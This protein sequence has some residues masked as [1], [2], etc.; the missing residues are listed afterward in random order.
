IF[1]DL[2]KIDKSET[3]HNIT[4]KSE[5]E[6]LTDVAGDLHHYLG[7]II[8]AIA[9]S[10]S[11]A[12]RRRDH[13]RHAL[14][15]VVVT[16]TVF[17]PSPIQRYQ[18][19]IGLSHIVKEIGILEVFGWLC[20][21]LACILPLGLKCNCMLQGLSSVSDGLARTNAQEGDNLNSNAIF[22]APDTWFF[23]LMS[24]Q[25]S[26]ILVSW[27]VTKKLLRD[28]VPFE[29]YLVQAEDLSKQKFNWRSTKFT[30][31]NILTINGWIPKEL[32]SVPA[33]V[34][35]FSQCKDN[36]A[37]S[38]QEDNFVEAVSNI[39]IARS[40]LISITFVYLR[41]NLLSSLEVKILKLVKQ[42]HLV[43]NQ[44]TLLATLPE[45]LNL[46]FLSV[47]EKM[48]KSLSIASQPRL[49][50]QQCRTC[51]D[52]RAMNCMVLME[53]QPSRKMFKETSV[54]SSL[55]R[56]EGEVSE[57]DPNTRR[58]VCND[59]A[60]DLSKNTKHHS[61][62]KHIDVSNHWLQDV[63]EK[64]LMKLDKVHTSKNVADMLTNV[65]TGNKLELCSKLAGMSFK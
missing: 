62:T 39:V 27:Y 60:M 34:S 57:L 48:L 13:R 55:A 3:S 51:I 53:W 49:Q 44:F 24:N 22:A 59:S 5:N 47:S 20:G 64:G 43:G 29:L 1:G 36:D 41:D 4:P 37:L 14:T 23:L 26:V 17:T 8:T 63:I 61:R 28:K 32:L 19:R 10:P 21:L 38:L 9:P 56:E 11:Q 65:V 33:F 25:A 12:S 54:H 2:K 7:S 30:R 58:R 40:S 35:R 45:P 15:I 42:L 50:K 52:I 46:E 18:V 31:F 6:T 16:F